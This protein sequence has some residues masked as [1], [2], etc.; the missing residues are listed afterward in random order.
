MSRR[1]KG[2]QGGFTLV[3]L[4]IVMLI[5]AII[6]GFGVPSFTQF[7]RQ[8]ELTSR[9]NS[10]LVALQLARSEA[11]SRGRPVMACP[12][13]DGASCSGDPG[14]WADGWLVA[15]DDAPAGSVDTDDEIVRVNSSETRLNSTGPDFVRFTSDG[16]NASDTAQT[17]ALERPECG[18]DRR[19]EIPVS[20][21]GRTQVNEVD[22]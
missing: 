7:L 21:T 17:I 6:A 13:T 5:V 8:G 11:I 3:E 20:P 15:T 1:A 9:A 19:R 14:D 18:T 12:S 4:L 22:C 2:Q 16:L 10:V